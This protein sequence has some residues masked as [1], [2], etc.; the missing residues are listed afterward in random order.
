MKNFNEIFKFKKLN[1]LEI[2]KEKYQELD[3]KYPNRL[4]IIVEKEFDLYDNGDN[5]NDVKDEIN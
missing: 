2:R 5:K 4:K 1:S 3:E